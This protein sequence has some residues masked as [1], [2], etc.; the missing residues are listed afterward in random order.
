MSHVFLKVPGGAVCA[1]YEHG[2]TCLVESKDDSELHSV[3]VSTHNFKRV[4]RLQEWSIDPISY[5]LLQ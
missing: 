4:E 1:L 3:H 2:L 5:R